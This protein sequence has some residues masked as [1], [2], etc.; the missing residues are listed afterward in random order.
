MKLVLLWTSLLLGAS[1]AQADELA[2]DVVPATHGA[3]AP[4]SAGLSPPPMGAASTPTAV[5]TEHEG[6][7]WKMQECGGSAGNGQRVGNIASNS[8]AQVVQRSF[9][10]TLFRMAAADTAGNIIGKTRDEARETRV[11]CVT[12]TFSDGTAD[13]A[14][15]LAG[16]EFD[17]MRLSYRQKVMVLFE[18][19]KATNFRF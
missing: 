18:D 15:K 9:L 6:K 4:V 10:G 1:F 3:S 19:G 17:A 8:V 2:A 11:V 12:V 13:Q 7:V 16:K 5:I 14:T